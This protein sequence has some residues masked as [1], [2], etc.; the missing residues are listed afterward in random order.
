[1]LPKEF[2]SRLKYRPRWADE[3]GRGDWNGSELDWVKCAHPL[4]P[5]ALGAHMV[6]WPANVDQ[7]FRIALEKQLPYTWNE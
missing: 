1:M 3:E 2:K 4:H 7:H 5:Q 6:Q